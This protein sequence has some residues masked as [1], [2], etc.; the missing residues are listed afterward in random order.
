[1]PGRYRY[2]GK[3][4]PHPISRPLHRHSTTE[5]PT[6]ASPPPGP[7]RPYRGSPRP[8]HS[9]CRNRSYWASISSFACSERR[10]PLGV[11][12][13]ESGK[14][15]CGEGQARVACRQ[16]CLHRRRPLLS[17]LAGRLARRLVPRVVVRALAGR[18]AVAR[19]AAAPAALEGGGG[20]GGVGAGGVGTGLGA[21]VRVCMC[22]CGRERRCVERGMGGMGTGWGG[23][24]RAFSLTASSR[25]LSLSLSHLP[26][27]GR[28]TRSG[29]GGFWSWSFF[30]LPPFLL[31]PL[32]FGGMDPSFL[33][34]W[35]CVSL[36]VGL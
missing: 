30:F 8:R 31:A 7:T 25:R 4:I 24:G 29:H 9:V 21:C 3:T 11:W 15:V 1:M 33:A 26:S 12:G 20:G 13:G 27:G 35:W 6:P 23:A 18:A 17:H 34:R 5:H 14:S 22:M 2:I 16:A 32:A 19:A 10:R 36:C 28:R